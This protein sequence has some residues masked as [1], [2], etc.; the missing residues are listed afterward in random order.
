MRYTQNY[1]IS[2]KLQ[3][4]HVCMTPR[5]V[6]AVTAYAYAILTGMSLVH[7]IHAISNI[8]GCSRD[9]RPHFDLHSVGSSFII[10]YFNFYIIQLVKVY[11]SG[12]YIDE[13]YVQIK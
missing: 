7:N 1:L 6:L 2:V 5:S 3:R 4:G 10:M 12:I 11:W 9:F 8:F 13:L